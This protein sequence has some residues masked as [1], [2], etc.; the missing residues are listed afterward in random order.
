[1]L[2]YSMEISVEDNE[3]TL[4]MIDPNYGDEILTTQPQQTATSTISNTV[5]PEQSKSN[6]K[7]PEP[8]SVNLIQSTQSD[9]NSVG[10]TSGTLSNRAED[11]KERVLRDLRKAFS[12]LMSMKGLDN[13]VELKPCCK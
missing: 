4:T 3:R 5:G 1:M 12:D 6:S 10:D 7:K 11:N 2:H 9:S 13:Y 8:V